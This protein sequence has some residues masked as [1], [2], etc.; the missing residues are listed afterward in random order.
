MLLASPSLTLQHLT[1]AWSKVQVSIVTVSAHSIA[2]LQITMF[3]HMQMSPISCNG[4][5]KGAYIQVRNPAGRCASLIPSHQ[6]VGWAAQ[7]FVVLVVPFIF[8]LS[9][10][11]QQAPE[12]IL[13][14]RAPGP[15]R[16]SLS[17]MCK[18]TECSQQVIRATPMHAAR[19]SF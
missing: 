2:S 19:M 9:I 7:Q 12:S 17:A 16:Q 14:I 4:S 6:K 3:S 1:S 15:C 10:D 13:V 11:V 18:P 5:G 8:K